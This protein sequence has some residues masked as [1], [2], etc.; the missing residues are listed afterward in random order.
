LNHNWS[1]PADNPGF[2]HC[3]LT[4]PFRIPP[5]SQIQKFIH[6]EVAIHSQHLSNLNRISETY[7]KFLRITKTAVYVNN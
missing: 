6:L 3:Q 5:F 7:R 2:N 4:P 1:D